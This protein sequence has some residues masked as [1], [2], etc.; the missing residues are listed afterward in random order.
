MA[1][2]RRNQSKPWQRSNERKR[3][4]GLR[5]IVA[6]QHVLLWA[7]AYVLASETYLLIQRAITADLLPTAIVLLVS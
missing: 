3:R 2:H 5:G 1:I 4:T 6:T 7:S